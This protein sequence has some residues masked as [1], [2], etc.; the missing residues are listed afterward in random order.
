MFFTTDTE[1][2]RWKVV[3]TFKDGTNDT[4]EIEEISALQEIVEFGPNFND[5]DNINI[6]YQLGV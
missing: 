2:K 3:I 6:T 1:T 5:I 4:Q